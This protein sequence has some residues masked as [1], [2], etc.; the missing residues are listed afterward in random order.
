LWSLNSQ[1]IVVGNRLIADS[2]C[3]SNNCNFT[4][5]DLTASPNLT[6]PAQTVTSGVGA[7]TLS[8]YNLNI[9][10]SSNIKVVLTN[11]VTNS[12]TIVTPTSVSAN[13][14]IFDMPNVES[15]YYLVCVRLDPIGQT[16]WVMFTVQNL[17]SSTTYYGSVMG[18]VLEIKGN[19]L[20]EKWPSGSAFSIRISSNGIFYDPVVNSSSTNNLQIVIPQGT[21]NQVFQI[22]LTN[23]LRQVS[24][25]KLTLLNSTT[26]YN[27]LLVTTALTPGSQ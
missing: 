23:P 1:G 15:G 2:D 26:P 22:A 25:V 20:P 10:P 6:T 21:I 19:G 16:N 3:P 13:D 8:G 18:G 5:D 17:L 27:Q 14:V 11:N 4:Y 7:I 12:K 9:I 24:N